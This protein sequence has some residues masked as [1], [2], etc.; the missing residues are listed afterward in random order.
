MGRHGVEGAVV[1]ADARASAG[2][3]GAEIKSM[4]QMGEVV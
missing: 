3:G 1:V 4:A 2:A